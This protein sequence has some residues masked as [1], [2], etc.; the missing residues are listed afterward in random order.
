MRIFSKYPQRYVL[1]NTHTDTESSTGTFKF[2]VFS[3]YEYV[4]ILCTYRRMET[5]VQHEF[6][7]TCN[8]WPY[9]KLVPS[10]PVSMVRWTNVAKIKWLNV[11]TIILSKYCIKITLL[12]R[13]Y[14]LRTS[15]PPLHMYST[16]SRKYAKN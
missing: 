11:C 9:K 14:L 8:Q 15:Q 3:N 12:T 6:I 2:R 1:K 4:H 16:F 13:I 5:F 10:R 7:C